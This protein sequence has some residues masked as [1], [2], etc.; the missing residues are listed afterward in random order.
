M[1]EKSLKV[2][3]IGIDFGSSRTVISCTQKGGV[4]I[5]GN[6]ASKRETRMI[7]SYGDNERYCGELGSAK[8]NIRNNNHK[9]LKN[10]N[11]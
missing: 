6:E 5:L 7:V 11:K 1:V 8:V 4:D 10:K 9:V 2:G 3:A